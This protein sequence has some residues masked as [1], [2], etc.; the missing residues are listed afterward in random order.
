MRLKHGDFILAVDD[1][2]VV[3]LYFVQMMRGRD[4][5]G[6]TVRLSVLRLK[7]SS[8]CAA[9]DVGSRLEIDLIRESY[10]TVNVKEG[11]FETL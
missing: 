6:S 2:S 10:Q 8:P 1:V 9:E 7:Y 5:V 4:I 11:L 3:T